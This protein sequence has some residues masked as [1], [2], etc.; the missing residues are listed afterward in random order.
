M[1]VG[2]GMGPRVG[3]GRHGKFLIQG[4]AEV[5]VQILNI[6]S[7]TLQAVQKS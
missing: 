7:G 5:S 6:D 3:H 1:S 2:L 4:L